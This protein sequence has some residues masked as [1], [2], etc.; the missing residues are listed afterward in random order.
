MA[1][2]ESCSLNGAFP[3]RSHV[4]YEG[5]RCPLGV[6]SAGMVIL[7]HLP[8]RAIE[9]YLGRVDLAADYGPQHA[10]AEIGKHVEATRKHGSL[11]N[12][13]LVVEGSWG[14]AAAVFDR[15]GSPRWTLTPTGVAHRFGPE[16][17]PQLGALLLQE[18][19]A[20]AEKLAR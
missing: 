1:V 20:L 15:S 8:D 4:L 14:V 16:R 12:P 11:V 7:A 9:D 17:I 6:V 18:A 19:Y 13:G 10:A 2:T 3:I 5:A